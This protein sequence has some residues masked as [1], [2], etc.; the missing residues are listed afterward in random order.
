MRNKYEFSFLDFVYLA[1]C[2][3][4]VNTHC[5]SKSCQIVDRQN[6]LIFDL[7]LIGPSLSAA[8]E[9][10]SITAMVILA[11]ATVTTTTAIAHFP[12]HKYRDSEREREKILR[13]IRNLAT[14][15]QN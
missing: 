11:P 5:D 7:R 9:R 14:P 13:L 1:T 4:V 15:K 10:Q 8:R 2:C 6:V 3:V 12:G